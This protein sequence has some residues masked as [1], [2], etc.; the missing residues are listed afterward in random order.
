MFSGAQSHSLYLVYY[1]HQLCGPTT[2][3]GYKVH[4]SVIVE[5]VIRTGS[6]LYRFRG[7]RGNHIHRPH[8]GSQMDILHSRPPENL[9]N[10]S[11]LIVTIQI[12]SKFREVLLENLQL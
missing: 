7:L 10:D 2:T 11:V 5:L 9:Q 3:T 12:W 4:V 1:S 8:R 6:A